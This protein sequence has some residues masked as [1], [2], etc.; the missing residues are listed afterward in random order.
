MGYFKFSHIRKLV[1]S[2]NYQFSISYYISTIIFKIL[3]TVINLHK[4]KL[5]TYFNFIFP[6]LGIKGISKY[7]NYEKK[8]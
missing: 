8:Y 3:A 2:A 4:L 6:Y 1:K 5:K 7:E